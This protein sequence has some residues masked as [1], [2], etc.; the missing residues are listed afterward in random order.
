[1]GIDV[2]LSIPWMFLSSVATRSR[3]DIHIDTTPVVVR[4]R[5]HS[6]L[7]IERSHI[8]GSLMSQ[9]IHEMSHVVHIGG[10]GQLVMGRGIGLGGRY[11]NGSDRH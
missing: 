10:I 7:K 9:I 2:K 8:S 1:M 4:G 5:I 6:V 11:V 3:S